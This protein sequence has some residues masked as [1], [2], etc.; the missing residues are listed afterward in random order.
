MVIQSPRIFRLML[1]EGIVIKKLL[2]VIVF[3]V[4]LASCNPADS[5]NLPYTGSP[6]TAS[7]GVP[8]TAGALGS[9]SVDMVGVNGHGNMICYTYDGNSADLE[10]LE[11]KATISQGSTVVERE[12]PS[13]LTDDGR[14]CFEIVD[15]YYTDLDPQTGL[16]T[17]RDGNMI[18]QIDIQ[19]PGGNVVE[20]HGQVLVLG[21]YTQVP[22]LSNI[23]FTNWICKA[24]GGWHKGFI[25][26]DF[27]PYPSSEYPTIVNTPVRAPIE[28]FL[29]VFKGARTDNADNYSI[30]IY[31][32]QTGYL[33]ELSHN[34]DSFYSSEGKWKSLQSLNGEYVQAGDIIARIGEMDLDSGMPHTHMQLMIVPGVDVTADPSSASRLLWDYY[35]DGEIPEVDFVTANL[36][37]DKSF[38]SF[39]KFLPDS[40][41][42]C[43]KF[44]WGTLQV[45]VQ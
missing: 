41:Y 7:S 26:W 16:L 34:A 43:L 22:L 2:H 15:G 29:Y 38:N 25:A 30:I 13:Q 40:V 10:G 33:V 3:L 9:F 37:I 44:A 28:G 18:V 17:P 11:I 5:V 14:S 8:T 35:L 39:L 24:N 1:L 36:F 27:V 32:P 45:P 23:Y 4:I 21:E 42:P 31:S 19:S 12:I 20:N 6:Q